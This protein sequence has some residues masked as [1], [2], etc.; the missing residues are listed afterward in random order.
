MSDEQIQTQTPPAQ[1]KEMEAG[2]NAGDRLDDLM[3]DKDEPI[4]KPSSTNVE[5]PPPPEKKDQPPVP[6]PGILPQEVKTAAEIKKEEDELDKLQRPEFRNPKNSELWD[7]LKAKSREMIALERKTREDEKRVLAEQVAEYRK[8]EEDYQKRINELMPFRA[9]IDVVADPEF[10]DKYEKPIQSKI[11]AASESLK[12]M[13]VNE[14][15]VK[16]INWKDDIALEELALAIEEKNKPA[17]NIFRRQVSEIASLADARENAVS[18]AR[19]K[20]DQLVQEQLKSKQLKSV[21][22]ETRTS[23]KVDE[24]FT[25]KDEK[26]VPRWWFFQ[27]VDATTPGFNDPKLVDR[28]N[29]F[30][31]AKMEQVRL[32]SSQQEPET[33]AE[34]A[35]AVVLAEVQTY[36]LEKMGQR[37]KELEDELKKRSNASDFSRGPKGPTP[38]PS[39][40]PDPS[41]NAEAALHQFMPAKFSE[42]LND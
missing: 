35:T 21:E 5:E 26:G 17:A 22:Y 14:E 29:N 1:L 40:R 20:H 30:V 41:Q 39:T 42:P 38:P 7:N 16:S 9:A 8:K 24:I 25:Q 12:K 34:M 23:K 28:H 11:K 13:G 3:R 33:Q 15:G 31:Q 2:P 19:T 27:K 6:K 36:Q 4:V 18:E 32:L 37:I 10:Q